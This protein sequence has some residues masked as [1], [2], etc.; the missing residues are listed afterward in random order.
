MYT[1]PEGLLFGLNA[2]ES[3]GASAAQ[4]YAD[5]TND[6]CAPGLKKVGAWAGGLLA[7]LWTPETSNET[8]LSLLP[9]GALG[10]WAG[11][12]FYQYYT[13]GTNYAGKWMSRGWGW[14]P[15]HK[16]GSGARK[17]LSLPPYNKATAVKKY[18]PKWH[19]PIVGPRK[20]KPQPQWGWNNKGAGSEYFKG[21]RF[22]D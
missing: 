7:S 10:K 13:K 2:G 15:P 1:D 22:P 16:V 11:R 3:F 12:P 21:W 17:A 8:F 20:P 14:K 4:Y 9:T 5:I 6:P 19:E 18:T